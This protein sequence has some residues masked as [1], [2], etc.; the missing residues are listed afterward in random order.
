VAV[1][2]GGVAEPVVDAHVHC[3]ASCLSTLLRV[4]DVAGVQGA[5]VLPGAGTTGAVLE[6]A[7]RVEPRRLRVL[8]APDLTLAGTAAW[9]GELSAVD[10]LLGHAAGMKLYKSASFGFSSRAGG[11]LSLLSPELEPLWAL[12][13]AHG[14][15][16]VVHCG[17][18]ADFWRRRPRLRA[19]QVRVHPE[20]RYAG[21][22]GIPSR[23]WMISSRDELFRRHPDVLFVGAH[24][25][26]FPATPAEL[27]RFLDLGPADT[28]A[29]LEEV[30]TFE[31][32]AVERLL[33]Q[34]ERDILWGSDLML[35]DA[36]PGRERTQVLVAAKFMVDSLR[37]A[38]AAGEVPMP[39]DQFPWRAR[40]LG[41]SGPLRESVLWR[42]ARRVYWDQRAE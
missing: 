40:G 21:M 3:A 9:V 34:H 4:M 37:L 13:A 35:W 26:G 10:R 19:K 14:K 30:V 22:P 29:A 28:S 8:V 20:Y 5:V 15:P 25:G 17:D 24:L 6:E 38:T 32:A 31:R 2:V 1:E 16:V 7:Q 36:V 33:R 11:R 27:A 12:A 18:P 23:R 41:L 39:A 42:N